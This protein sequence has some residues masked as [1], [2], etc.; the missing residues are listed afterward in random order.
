MEA[1]VVAAVADRWSLKFRGM[2]VL[3][4]EIFFLYPCMKN[5]FSTRKGDLLRGPLLKL[6]ND[7]LFSR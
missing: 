4:S 1:P 2:G 6:G 5:K 3:Q 7:V